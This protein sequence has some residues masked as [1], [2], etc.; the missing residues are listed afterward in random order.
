[1]NFRVGLPIV[2]ILMLANLFLGIYVNLSVWYKLT[3]R[4][5]LGAYV[6]I[7][8]AIVTI[9]LNL[10]WIPTMGYMGSAWA[11][12][13]CYAL[14]A[15]VSFFLGQKYYPIPYESL[16]VCLYVILVV[17]LYQIFDYATIDATSVMKHMTSLVFMALFAV[18][19][20]IVDGRSLPK[21]LRGQ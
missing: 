7:G 5:M 13:V 4:T 11:T 16:K 17:I 14:M 18:F 2:P 12:L 21:L 15:A 8:G 6:S 9:G 1:V 19:V 10:L 20:F 3:D